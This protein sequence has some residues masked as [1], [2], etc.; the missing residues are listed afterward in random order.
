MP[1]QTTMSLDLPHGRCVVVSLPE[2]GIPESRVTKELSEET[3]TY[4]RTLSPRRTTSWIGGRVALRRAAMDLG[5]DPGA[6]LPNQHGAP[7]LAAGVV[8]SISHKSQLAA[9]LAALEDGWMR[10]VDI[11]ELGRERLHIASRVLTPNEEEEV[12]R[13]PENERWA[14]LLL[15]FS[16]KEAVYKAIHPTLQ[17]YVGFHEVMVRPLENGECEIKLELRPDESEFEIEARWLRTG[18]IILSSCRARPKK[19]KAR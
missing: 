18:D 13:L 5:L 19:E 9:G 1:L 2:D 14:A 3:L 11:E 17:R 15:R 12:N 10:G 7:T 8:G 16:L 6:L 4:G